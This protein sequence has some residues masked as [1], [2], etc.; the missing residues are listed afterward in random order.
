MSKDKGASSN[1]PASGGQEPPASPA[2]QAPTSAGATPASSTT[3]P[4][5]EPSGVNSKTKKMRKENKSLRERLRAAEAANE[6]AKKSQ[7]TDAEKQAARLAE[8]EAQALTWKQKEQEL[9]V[10]NALSIAA[11]KRGVDPELAGKLLNWATLKFDEESGQPKGIGKALDALLE[12]YPILKGQ[13]QQQQQPTIGATNP[14]RSSNG[15]PS[16]GGDPKN[17]PRLSD[18]LKWE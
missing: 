9:L 8:L 17:P 12:Q 16:Q 5:Q 7:Q 18:V 3:T 6:A 10:R 14:Q 1:P 13:P 11:T 15:T 2:G 4:G